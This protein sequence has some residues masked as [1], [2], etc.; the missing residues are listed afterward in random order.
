MPEDLGFMSLNLRKNVL[1]SSGKEF[2]KPY[3]IAF[4]INYTMNLAELKSVFLIAV[5]VPVRAVFIKDDFDR[6]Q[7]IGA[8][9][10]NPRRMHPF[11]CFTSRMAVTI[12]LSH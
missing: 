7:F 2:A 3:T 1:Y 8:Q 6:A 9:G 5:A 4:L 11:Q 10:N 12:I